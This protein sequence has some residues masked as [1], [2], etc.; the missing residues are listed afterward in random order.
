MLGK[1][2]MQELLFLLELGPQLPIEV[3]SRS[4]IQL[5]RVA[6]CLVQKAR[7]LR[8]LIPQLL[9]QP[10]NLGAAVGIRRQSR[11]EQRVKDMALQLN[12]AGE[13]LPQPLHTET[14]LLQI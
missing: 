4:G 3:K 5:L 2:G 8:D 1:E 10:V 9:L 7:Q 14:P 12:V 11:P 13:A 6:L